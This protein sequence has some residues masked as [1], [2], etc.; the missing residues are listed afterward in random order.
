MT[1]S[2]INIDHELI[3]FFKAVDYA[4]TKDYEQDHHA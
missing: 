1:S 2:R 4:T 3:T